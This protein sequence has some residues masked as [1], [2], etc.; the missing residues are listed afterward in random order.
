MA[1]PV[2]LFINQIPSEKRT[3]TEERNQIQNLMEENDNLTAQIQSKNEDIQI[4]AEVNPMENFL[5]NPGLAHL[6]DNI[7]DNLDFEDIKVCRDINQS[8]QQKLDNPLFWLR[9]FGG[10]SNKNQK[11]WIKVIQSVKNSDKERAIV[12]YLQWNLKKDVLVDLPC[13]TSPAV[14]DEFRK[15]IWECCEKQ[16]SSDENTEIVKILAPLTN[17]PNAPNEYGKTPIYW[18]ARNGHTEIV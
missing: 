5:N 9:K 1:I 17:N 12:S 4:N 6:A 18:A 10:L 15:K 14:Q 2:N 11:D 3:F 13:Y 16:E 8:S 7:F